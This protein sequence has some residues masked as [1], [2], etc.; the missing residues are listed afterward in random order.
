MIVTVIASPKGAA[1]LSLLGIASSLHL[2]MTPCL[3][4]LY[5]VFDYRLPKG[6]PANSSGPIRE[7]VYRDKEV[8]LYLS[9][10]SILT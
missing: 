9:D 4:R 5:L 2:A 3:C 1:I 10:P 7:N 6:S 8:D